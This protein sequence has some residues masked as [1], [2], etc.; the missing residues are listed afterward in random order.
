M[1][2]IK[3]DNNCVGCGLCEAMCHKQAITIEENKNG[4]CKTI[5]ENRCDRCGICDK[6]CPIERLKKK[7]DFATVQ[8]VAVGKSRNEEIV[9]ASASGGIMSEI[10]I[11]LFQTNKIEVAIVAFYDSH[12]HIYGDVIESEEEVLEHSGFY[13]HTSKQLINIQKIRQ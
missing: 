9:H 1:F 3:S 5:V 7:E 2:G 12:A 4:S 10:L 11:H 13:Y 8:K 6:F